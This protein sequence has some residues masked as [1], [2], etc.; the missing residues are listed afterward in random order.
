MFRN[1]ITAICL[2]GTAASADALLPRLEN[3][4]VAI[5]SRM[6][7]LGGTDP[8]AARWGAQR[9]AQSACAL[10]ELEHL[11]GRKTA[12]R[13]V[14]EVEK[15][16]YQSKSLQNNW[17]FGGLAARIH[18]DSGIRMQRDLVPITRKCGTGL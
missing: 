18:R 6:L 3:A 16:V 4:Q 15:A 5:D 11:R 9:R 10:K 13:Y 7:A 2:A 14:R 1:L 8:N 12:E 17:E